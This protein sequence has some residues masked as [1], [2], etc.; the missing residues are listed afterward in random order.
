MFWNT[1]TGAVTG[2]LCGGIA[3]VVTGKSHMYDTP[4]N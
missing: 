4:A 1:V 2:L 3:R